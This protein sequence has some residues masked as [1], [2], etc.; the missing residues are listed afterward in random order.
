MRIFVASPWGVMPL[1]IDNKVF[2]RAKNQRDVKIH[3]QIMHVVSD[4]GAP[5]IICF[6]PRFNIPVDKV[7]Q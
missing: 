6:P 3:L 2:I 1:G 4:R 5:V 7:S